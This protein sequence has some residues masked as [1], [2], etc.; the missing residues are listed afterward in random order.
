MHDASPLSPVLIVVAVLLFFFLGI[1]IMVIMDHK[2]RL[3]GGFTNNP[4]SLGGIRRDH[5]VIAFLTATILLAIIISLVLELLI[6]FLA[7]LGLM[8]QKKP[9]PV[10]SKLIAERTAERLR[11]FHNLP[12]RM[13]PSDKKNACTPCHGDYP[14]SKKPMVRS[15]LNMHTQFIGCMTCH[16]DEDK[17]PKQAIVLRWLNYSGTVVKG[18]PF[19]TAYDPKTGFLVQ[20]ENYSSKIVPYEKSRGGGTLLEVTAEDPRAREFIETYGRLSEQDRE[21]FKKT[22]HALAGKGRACSQCHT[23]ESKS[24]VP[25]RALGFS[26]GRISDLTHLN[27]VGL[28][29]K[30]KHFYFPSLLKTDRPPSAPE[31]VHESQVTDP[32]SRPGDW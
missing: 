11:H 5:P 21:A 3:P 6:T 17:V 8:T 1:A 14:H 24:Y 12:V 30:Y 19:G 22:F 20:T 16:V 18:P 28:I 31:E 29:E 7:S 23:E 2:A 26:D 9:P 27:I 4:F 32:A 25:F 15:L 10:L 13:P